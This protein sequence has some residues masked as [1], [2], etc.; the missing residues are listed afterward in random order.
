MCGVCPVFVCVVCADV[1][2]RARARA[3]THTHM[4]YKYKQMQMALERV[5]K[6]NQALRFEVDVKQSQVCD[7]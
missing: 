3:H 2:T 4:L 1:C 6:E 5:M 7:V